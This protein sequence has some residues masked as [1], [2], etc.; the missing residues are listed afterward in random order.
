LDPYPTQLLAAWI[1]YSMQIQDPFVLGEAIR[2]LGDS[3]GP[4]DLRLREALT[5][6]LNRNIGGVNTASN[7]VL[8]ADSALYLA[9]FLSLNGQFETAKSLYE[10]GLR[11]MPE[12]AEL[13]NDYGFYLLDRNEQTDRAIRMIELAYAQNPNSSHIVDSMGWVRYKQ[14]QLFDEVPPGGGDLRLGAVSLLRRAK[15]LSA[16]EDPDALNACFTTNHLGDALWA[17]GRHDE[18]VRQWTEAVDLAERASKGIQGMQV[19][20]SLEIELKELITQASEKVRAASEDRQ[21]AIAP[22]LD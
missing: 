12:H 7:K 21:P 13:N 6:R 3:A 20:L 9:S 14:G 1:D 2:S 5:Y 16:Q 22:M 15:T 4:Q 17:S 18:A 11:I 8:I 10:E 19:P